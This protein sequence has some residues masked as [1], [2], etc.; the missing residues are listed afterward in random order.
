MTRISAISDELDPQTIELAAE[1][2]DVLAE[3]VGAQFTPSIEAVRAAALVLAWR[4][5]RFP[6]FERRAL[7]DGAYNIVRLNALDCD[8]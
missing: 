8:A 5:Q 6:S 2:H 7:I 4:L 3:A 1:V